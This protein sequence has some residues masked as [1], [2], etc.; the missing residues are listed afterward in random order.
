MSL[1]RHHCV[2]RQRHN[3]TP[4]VV[5]LRQFLNERLRRSRNQRQFDV[6]PV[7]ADRVIH[8]GPAL[9]QRL[10][11]LRNY[12]PVRTL[13]YRNFADVTDQQIALAFTGGRDGHAADV[14]IACRCDQAKILSNLFVDVL[15]CNADTGRGIQVE[16]SDFAVVGHEES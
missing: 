12:D 3:W 4:P 5:R 10:A 1:G 2:F 7:F 16:H 13:P 8:D 15:F 14:L 11:L 6:L 9:Q